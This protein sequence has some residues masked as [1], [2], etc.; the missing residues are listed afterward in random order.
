MDCITIFN[1]NQGLTDWTDLSMLGE[2]DE[3]KRGI[4]YVNLQLRIDG[5]KCYCQ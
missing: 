5:N 3:G 4:G 1:T 2:Q